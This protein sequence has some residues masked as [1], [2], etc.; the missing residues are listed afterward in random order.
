MPHPRERCECE[1]P[2]A[3]YT[4]VPGI[5]AALENGRVAPGAV[6][7][8]C[9]FCQQYPSDAAAL[10]KLR[11]LGLANGEVEDLRPWTVQ[12]Y[13]IVRVE[14]SDVVAPDPQTAANRV[15]DRFDWELHASQIELA[16]D[17]EL[18]VLLDEPEQSVRRRLRINVEELDT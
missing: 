5:L 18:L 14:F 17:A 13:A 6:V 8:R 7:E 3:F 9:D 1:L 4:G 15:L 10:A 12:C 2:G 16:D 11:E